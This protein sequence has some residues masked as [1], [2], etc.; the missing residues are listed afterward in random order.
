MVSREWEWQA[1]F[2]KTSPLRTCSGP[3]AWQRGFRSFQK[4]RR[5]HLISRET[6]NGFML[7]CDQ[8]AFA[9]FPSLSSSL[10]SI[11]PITLTRWPPKTNGAAQ[12]VQGQV[13]PRN[14]GGIKDREIS[15]ANCRVT[16]R[17]VEDKSNISWS[18]EKK[19]LV[20]F[21]VSVFQSSK[22]IQ[23]HNSDK[24]KWLH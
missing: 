4:C 5:Q 20:R 17:V 6:R 11:R 18:W 7:G 3:T 16:E 22:S 21:P 19:I 9:G 2:F 24:L 12:R 10:S 8:A 1:K 14:R 13:P 23:K 15:S